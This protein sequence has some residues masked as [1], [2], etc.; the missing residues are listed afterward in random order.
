NEPPGRTEK[1][2]DIGTDRRLSPEVR[3]G[4]RE[5]AQNTPQHPLVRRRVRAQPLCSCA[6]DCCRDHMRLTP[7]RLAFASLS[8]PALPLQGRVKW[9]AVVARSQAGEDRIYFLQPMSPF[10]AARRIVVETICGSPHPGSLSLRS[11]SRPSPFRGG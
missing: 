10:V 9:S 11:A 1:I 3:A 4:H 6:S 2:N 5:L 7:P 8:E